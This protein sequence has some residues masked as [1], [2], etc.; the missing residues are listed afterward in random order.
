MPNKITKEITVY[1]SNMSEDVWPLI[2]A[3]SNRYE[4]EYEIV[5]NAGLAEHDL[6][7]FAGK[8]NTI[9]IM[10]KPLNATYFSYFQQISQDKNIRF[11]SPKIHTGEICKDIISDKALFK[12]LMEIAKSGNKF[13]LVS[14]C[15]S[16]QFLELVKVLREN[17]VNV[18]ISESPEEP[19][20]WTVDFFG[21]KSGIRQ[22]A[23][24]SE[25]QEPDFKMPPGRISINIENTA[26][27]AAKMYLK[28]KGIVIKTNKGHSG[29]GILIFRKGDLPQGYSDCEREILTFF[30]KENYWNKFPIIVEK[31]IDPAKTIGGGF[32]NVEFRIHKNGRIEFLYYCAIRVTKSGVFQGVEIHNS[33]LSDQ[34]AAQVIDTGFFLGEKLATQGY[35]GYYDMD[36]IAAKNGDIYTTESNVRR[37]GGTHVYYLAR[38]FFGKDFLYETYILSNN[39]YQ[40]KL[41]QPV[42]AVQL[43]DRL[44]ILRYERRKREGLVITGTGLLAH[45]RF[46]YIIFAPTKSRAEKL[47]NNMMALLQ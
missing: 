43:F 16:A 2:T 38:H 12:K 18:V 31:Y 46:G 19:D 21:S 10:P 8:D 3:M 24:T 32:P 22:L 14:Y 15:V 1:I 26:K 27:M 47:E 45:N 9:L 28:E 25:I 40:I 33:V 39:L 35:R 29:A 23:Q 6:F 20:S 13:N 34:V 37:T 44:K 41:S 5:E 11:L 7:S 4:R 42:T 36:F 17:N 30:R